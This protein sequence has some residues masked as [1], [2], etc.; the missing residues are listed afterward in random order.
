LIGLAYK[1]NV[2]DTRESPAFSLI[3]LLESQ[4]AEVAYYDPFVPKIPPTRA[5]AG[6]GGRKSIVWTNA[7]LIKYD[8]TLIC[9]DHDIINYEELVEY[10]KLVIDTRNATA[11]INDK[12]G[13]IIKA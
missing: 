5:H 4:G 1:K 13:K 11:S 12:L 10:S 6:L 7:N 3:V 2:D 9:T 8:A